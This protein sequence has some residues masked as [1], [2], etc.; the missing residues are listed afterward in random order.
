MSLLA[1]RYAR[2]LFE[3]ALA[4]D[5][6]DTIAGD[7]EAIEGELQDPRVRQ[8]ALSPDTPGTARKRAFDALTKGRHG[9]VRNLGGVLLA[10]HRHG[11]LPQLRP[12]FRR[13]AMAHRGELDAVMETAVPVDDDTLGRVEARAETL[14]GKKVLLEVKQNP[15]LIGGI[16]LRIGNTLWDNSV[17]TAIE[18]LE[19][20]LRAVPI[21]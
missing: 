21:G 3:A 9:L 14:C 18:E 10:R 8:F 17:A 16:R 11:L 7:L 4:Q 5:A 20:A 13:L 19:R 15:E 2:A 6:V 12:A 1:N